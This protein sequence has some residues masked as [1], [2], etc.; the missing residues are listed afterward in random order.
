MRGHIKSRYK[1]SQTIV[2]DL[3]RDP[4]TG[5]RKQ[6][7]ISIKGT[8]KDA[9][10]RLAELQHQLDTGSFIMP[11][12]TTLAEFL[13][14][15][16]RDY[17]QPSLSPRSLEGYT[18]IIHK[19]L[20]PALGNITLIRLK[21]EHLQ[22][23][24]AEKIA[25]GLSNLTVRHHHTLLHKTLSTAVSWGI[26]SRNVAD[27][28][29]APRTQR[30]DMQTWDEREMIQFLEQAKNS[31]Y[32]ALFHTALFTGMRRSELLALRWSDVDF[33]LSQVSVNRSLHC[34]HGGKIIYRPTKTAKGRRAIALTPSS[35]NVLSDHRNKCT[36]DRMSLNSRLSEEDLVFCHLDGTP[37]LPNSITH[38]WI[39]TVRK[40]GLKPIRLH[41]ARH[42][43]ASIM[44]KQQV[45]PKIVQERLGHASISVT[46]D[47]YS[48]VAP[49]LQQAAAKSFDE[50][51]T[52]QYTS[53]KNEAIK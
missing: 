4:L 20:I 14:Q 32:Y 9:E 47:T 34:L 23:Y 10:K 37:Y 24:Y 12:K 51:F 17:A 13:E 7:W 3:G 53:I 8:R 18:H 2:L 5:K 28:I 16:L 30:Q 19:H 42:T 52:N 33:I 36:A 50:A 39:K 31:P 22:R 48:H 35:F 40:S 11:S 15:W 38:A 46:L 43:H 41:D 1:G 44:L 25:A 45:H 6:K 29:T 21:A 26:L 49:G 27:A